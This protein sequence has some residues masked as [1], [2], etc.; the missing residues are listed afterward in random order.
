MKLRCAP[1]DLC[2][3]TRGVFRDRFITVTRLDDDPRAPEP[4]WLYEGASLERPDNGNL[5]VSFFDRILQPMG[6][7]GD[8]EADLL[9]APLPFDIARAEQ[10]VVLDCFA[11]AFLSEADYWK[12][13]GKT[14]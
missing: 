1:G 14:Q 5:Q 9:L 10:E 13:K 4:A 6:K 7:P 12:W 3:I 2:R 8:D 11:A